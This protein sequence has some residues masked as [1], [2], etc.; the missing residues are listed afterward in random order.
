MK[1]YHGTN[2]DFE[3]IDLDKSIP[4]KDFGRGFYLTDILQQAERM[5]ERKSRRFGQPV[6]QV[7]EV[8]ENILY[9]IS[10]YEVKAFSSPDEEWAEFILANRERRIPPYKHSYDVVIGPVADDGIAYILSRYTEGTITL[11]EALK[12]LR[13]SKLNNQYCFCT[14]K[15]LK[16]LKRIWP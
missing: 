6:V 3:R 9:N 2:I 12:E 16:L 11:D 13:F 7:Y 8:D 5:A 1:L 10:E 15:S 14:E 4:Y